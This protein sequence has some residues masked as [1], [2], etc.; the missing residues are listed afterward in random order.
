MNPHALPSRMTVGQ[1]IEAP[2]S[3]AAVL[4]GIVRDATPFTN[5]NMEDIRK[6]LAYRGFQFS[7]NEIMYNGQTGEML[8]TPVSINPTYYQRLKHMVQD[9]I[10]AR[11]VG[12]VQKLTRQPTEG[13]S[14]DGGL[15]VGEMERDCFIA[16]GI[17]KYLVEKMLIS[18]DIYKVW[19]SKKTGESIAVNQNLGI[20]K[21][22]LTDIVETDE[23]VNV[24]MPW[25]SNLFINEL[26]SILIKVEHKFD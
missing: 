24:V 20:Y 11:S 8:D 18:S 7:G 10:H 4:N 15:R 5:F 23:I 6:E 21:N 19:M 13:R 16:H 12:P 9:K 17:S 26:K 22:G 3:K 14:R 25:A 1:M 2:T